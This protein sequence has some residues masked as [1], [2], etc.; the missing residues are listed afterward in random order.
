MVALTQLNFRTVDG[1]VCNNSSR[2][3]KWHSIH[4]F[5]DLAQL[6]LPGAPPQL[7]SRSR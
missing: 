2:S 6:A 1:K 7:Q 5:F 4:F 3:G